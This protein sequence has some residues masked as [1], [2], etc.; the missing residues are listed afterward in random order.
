MYMYT[1]SADVFMS[2]MPMLVAV[3]VGPAL[4][5][6]PDQAAEGSTGEDELDAV[7][8]S[9]RHLHQAAGATGRPAAEGWQDS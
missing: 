2:V 7:R 5:G 1:T 9:A 8:Q 3:R 4:P 6:A